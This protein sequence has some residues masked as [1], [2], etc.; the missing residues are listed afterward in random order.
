MARG[1]ALNEGLA[2]WERSYGG[3]ELFSPAQLSIIK[4]FS[5]EEDVS[6]MKETSAVVLNAWLQDQR[7]EWFHSLTSKK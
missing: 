3:G 6:D 2:P 5:G 4:Y 7:S 1:V